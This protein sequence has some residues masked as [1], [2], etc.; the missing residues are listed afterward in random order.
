MWAPDTAMPYATGQSVA[1]IAVDDAT[2]ASF[3]G[4]VFEIVYP[5]AYP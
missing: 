3:S 1:F 5:S 4:P 2:K